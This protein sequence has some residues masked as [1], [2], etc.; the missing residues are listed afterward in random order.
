VRRFLRAFEAEFEATDTSIPNPLLYNPKSGVV[1][2]SLGDFDRFFT[3]CGKSVDIQPAKSH[4]TSNDSSSAR[5]IDSTP[6][7]SAPDDDVLGETSD[8]HN[9]KL[10]G[11]EVRWKDQLGRNL[12]EVRRRS[13]Y[14]VAGELDATVIAR[15]VEDDGYESDIEPGIRE[16][17]T[18]SPSVNRRNES[19]ALLPASVAPQRGSFVRPPPPIPTIHVNPSVIQPLY[20][21]T[22]NEQKAKLVK[23]L[24]RSFPLESDIINSIP[25]LGNTHDDGIHVFVDCSNIVIGF[26]NRLRL[27]RR[28]SPAAYVRQPP[29]SYL[30]LALVFERGRSVKR[31]VLVGSNPR[32]YASERDL[33]DYMRE[34]QACG[35]EVNMLERVQKLKRPTPRK[36]KYGSGNGYATTSGQSSGSETT[37]AGVSVVAEQGVDEIL[38]MKLLESMARNP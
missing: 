7:S 32:P 4:R 11:K 24:L 31:R 29:I 30:S 16:R 3:F 17:S 25:R 33:P 26:Q 15:L 6:A 19:T 21:L 5:S 13:T 23:K 9:T 36:K 1:P 27:N 18:H 14:G 38:Q 12:T 37:F 35:Y 22:V 8:N 28:I 10:A 20:T 2:R 34:A